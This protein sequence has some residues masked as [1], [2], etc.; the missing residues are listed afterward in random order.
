MGYGAGLQSRNECR[1]P[2][3]SVEMACKSSSNQSETL[4]PW[5]LP[6]TEETLTW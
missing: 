4:K 6:L 3:G 2:N 1:M 5:L